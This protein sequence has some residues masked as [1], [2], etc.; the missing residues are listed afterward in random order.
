ML[1]Y[2]KITGIIWLFVCISVVH[3]QTLKQMGAFAKYGGERIFCEY[4]NELFCAGGYK[5]G[6]AG[7]SG[8]GFLWKWNGLDWVDIP[9]CPDSTVMCM[10][11]FQDK[12]YLGGWFDY[13]ASWDGQNWERHVKISGSAPEPQSWRIVKLVVYNDELIAGGQF[14]VARKVSDEPWN[15]VYSLFR[16]NGG[17]FLD[18]EG[19][20]LYSGSVD[21]VVTT[22]SIFK[23]GLLIAGRTGEILDIDSLEHTE[24]N[25]IAKWDGATL[26][27]TNFFYIGNNSQYL[28]NNV[29]S[30][31]FNDTLFIGSTYGYNVNI[32]KWDGENF[33]VLMVDSASYGSVNTII[34]YKNNIYFGGTFEYIKSP[35]DTIRYLM[36]YDG[37]K[38]SHIMPQPLKFLY[39][40]YD[41]VRA[42][43][44]R[45]DT[46]IIGGSFDLINNEGDTVRNIAYFTDSSLGVSTQEKSNILK[47]DFFIY[48]NP[49][50]EQLIIHSQNNPINEPVTIKIMDVLGRRLYEKV[51]IY[52]PAQVSL[53]DIPE[54]V[55]FIKITSFRDKTVLAT[56]KFVNVR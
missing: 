27:P 14:V 11:V 10:A 28:Y 36:K 54:G 18:F 24:T 35:G 52:L 53:E 4:N 47:K 40:K 23:N 33:N 17:S 34:A 15:Y 9:G 2:I 16:W 21:A 38:F 29:S 46:L 48:K 45:N 12:L 22:F 26:S 30:Y 19:K 32:S 44:V 39:P 55:L 50:S 13:L 8:Y 7:S 20:G 41:V 43:H 3:A 5:F 49:E 42:F 1:K 25:G 6:T 31:N 51:T 56:Q 37:K